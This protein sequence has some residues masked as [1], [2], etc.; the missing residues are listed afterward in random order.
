LWVLKKNELKNLY[1][2]ISEI[3]SLN[4]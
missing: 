2:F 4:G 1:Y 3:K